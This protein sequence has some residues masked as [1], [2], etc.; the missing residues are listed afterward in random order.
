[1]DRPNGGIQEQVFITLVGEN[2]ACTPSEIGNELG[3]R[4]QKIQYHLDKLVAQG[5]VTHTDDGYRCQ[6]VFTDNE[7]QRLF[8]D[9]LA[10]ILPEVSQRLDLDPESP[11]EDQTIIAFNC[12]RMYAALELL[13]EPGYHDQ[14]A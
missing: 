2:Q 10:D 1:M 11:P 13:Y 12:I 8:V 7:F 3:E 5:L 9:H 4:R 6:P 14:S